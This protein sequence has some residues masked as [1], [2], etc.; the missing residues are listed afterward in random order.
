MAEESYKHSLEI[1]EQRL[2]LTHPDLTLTLANLGVFYTEVGRYREAED[3]YRRSLVI[4]ERAA[5]AL[6]GR[7]GSHAARARKNLSSS[8]EKTSAESTLARAVEL[9]R[10]NPVAYAE[11]PALLDTY[12]AVLKS[13]G[14]SDDA[15]RLRA[16]AQRTRAAMASRV[17]VN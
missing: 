15:Q 10:H 12:A 6:D 5:P 16:E 14:K 11:I 2:G 13:L 3:Q 17:R 4:L 9:A 8:G 1:P 7:T